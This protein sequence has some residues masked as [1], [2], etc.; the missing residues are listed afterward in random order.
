MAIQLVKVRAKIEMGAVVAG[1]PP[2]G[3]ENQILSFNVD[4]SRGQIGTFSASLKIKK[5]E[6]TGGIVNNA[7]VKIWAGTATSYSNNQIFTGIIRTA[8]ISPNRDDPE[9]V[10]LNISGNDV[11]SR[12]NGKKYTRRCRSSKGVWVSIEGVAR[13]GLR[14]SKLLYV[15]GD[16]YIEIFGG[17]LQE[18]NNLTTARTPT[19]PENVEQLPTEFQETRPVLE[20]EGAEPQ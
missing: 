9:F 5:G 3:H 11:L 7:E 20:I 10:I 13:E 6:I 18:Q 8:N 16:P 15:K 14:D 4:K 19:R 12:L 2:L 17:E 1:T